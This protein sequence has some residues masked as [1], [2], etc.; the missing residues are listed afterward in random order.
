LK[1]VVVYPADTGACGL[2]RI[3][4]PAETLIHRGYDVHI[5]T[6]NSPVKEGVA[7]Q[8]AAEDWEL[9]TGI[10]PDCDIVVIQRPSSIKAPAIVRYL[11]SQGI[12][13][14]IEIDDDFRSL[15][16]RNQAWHHYQ[17]H[18]REKNGNGQSV[19]AMTK[20]ISLADKVIVS[21]PALAAAYSTDVV[22]ENCIPESFLSTPRF[23]DP[24]SLGWSGSMSVHQGDL[25][26]VGLGVR[27]AL[28]TT[29]WN[30][31][32]V[33]ESRGV[34]EELALEGPLP[35][36]G[37]VSMSSYRV[38]VATLTAGIAPLADDAFNRS[39]SW[40]KTLEYGALGVP[41]V[42]SDLPEYNRLG[43]G[44]IARKPKMWRSLLTKVM[45][46]EDFRADLIRE[47]RSIAEQ[48][49]YEKQADK[50]WRAW[51]E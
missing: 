37:W 26:V 1:K 8:I 21:T 47:G 30:F 14:V 42:A 24:M 16:S 3:R 33:G 17:K 28:K 32:V 4:Y 40:L 20:A 44:A 2:Y 6:D 9:K 43:I 27:D 19:A 23:P 18:A 5:A 15:T 25:K 34:A 7:D 46:D 49:T 11:K 36:T 45:L 39:K 10:V 38:H 12:R 13:V 35:E 41:C 51:S 48:W 50:W 29:G 22:V 31:R